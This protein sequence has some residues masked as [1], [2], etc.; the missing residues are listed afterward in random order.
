M[1]PLVLAGGV[2]LGTANAFVHVWAYNSLDQRAKVRDEARAKGVWPPPGGGDRLLTM[3][4]KILMP[5]AF[6]PLQ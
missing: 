4:N 6:S 3:E 1:S 5:S 2:D